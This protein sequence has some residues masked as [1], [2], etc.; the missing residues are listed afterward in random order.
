MT[1]NSYRCRKNY[2]AKWIL[3]G[4]VDHLFTPST[5]FCLYYIMF[6]FVFS[7]HLFSL[8]IY[9]LRS[10]FVYIILH[11]YKYLS[12][13]AFHP[14]PSRSKHFALSVLLCKNPELPAI[15][16]SLYYWDRI[17]HRSG[18]FRLKMPAEL[19]SGSFLWLIRFPNNS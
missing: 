17:P 8:R 9:S 1:T 6:I 2:H 19:M 15:S 3:A 10:R 5:Y 12:R 16:R 13:Q 7:S 14:H 18:G 11:I 4:N